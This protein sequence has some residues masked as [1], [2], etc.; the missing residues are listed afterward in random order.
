MANDSSLSS[1]NITDGNAGVAHSLGTGLVEISALSA[2]IGSSTAEQL[3]LGVS[4]SL[5]N[6]LER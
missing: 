1:H 3:A 5:P 4:P 6:C 2:L